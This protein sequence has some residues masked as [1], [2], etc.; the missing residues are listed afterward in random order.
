MGKI[1]PDG[2]MLDRAVI[3]KS[4]RVGVPA[5]AALKLD[6]ALEV[7]VE[8]FEECVAFLGRELV[9]TRREAAIDEERLLAAVGVAGDHGM[10]RLRPSAGRWRVSL[11]ADIKLRTVMRR[12]EAFDEFLHYRRQRFVSAD[13]AD[14]ARVTA[15]DFRR[16]GDVEHRAHGRLGLASHVAVPHFARDLARRLV[17]LHHV[18]LRVRKVPRFAPPGIVGM[19]VE[20]AEQA[21]EAFVVLRRQELLAKYEYVI[22]VERVANLSEL[23]RRDRLRQINAADL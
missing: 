5:Y 18:D 19:D 11:H 22:G 2:V 20:R 7:P 1:V 4:Q 8:E 23:L 14:E 9:D 6:M 16:P 21:A 3:P 13:R 15:A 10:R 12:G 17:R